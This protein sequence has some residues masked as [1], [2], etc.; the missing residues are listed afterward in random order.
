VGGVL[1]AQLGQQDA[2]R[3]SVADDVVHR[4]QQDVFVRRPAQH[5]QPQ[6][7]CRAEVEGGQQLRADPLVL[8]PRADHPQRHRHRFL[9]HLHGP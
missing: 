8:G 4:Q 1:V 5:G 9:D 6:Q 7:R 3:P 2:Q